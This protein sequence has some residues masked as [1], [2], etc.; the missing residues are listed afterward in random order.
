[1]DDFFA[2]PP[3]RPHLDEPHERYQSPPWL[4]PP[5][6]VLPGVVEL[7]LVL[8]RTERVAVCVSGVRAYPTGLS[9]QLITMGGPGS[10]GLELDPHA[11]H[12]HMARR[13]GGD[14]ELPPDLLRFG[15]ELPDGRR[16]TNVANNP[17]LQMADVEHDEDDEHSFTPPGPVLTDHG[18]GGGGADWNQSMW[19]WP[20]PGPGTLTLACEWPAAS[21]PL[22]KTEVDTAPI[23]AA[24]ERAQ[25]IFEFPEPPT[26]AGGHTFTIRRA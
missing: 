15:V 23:L 20:L 16:V 10:E 21:I 5:L 8:A 13:P 17:F 18:G 22:T 4:G 3:A 25:V 24:V 26:E 1:M 11:I 12:R 19:L 6:G 2:P 9:F 7:E 14:S